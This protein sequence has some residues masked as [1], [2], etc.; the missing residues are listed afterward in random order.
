MPY[1]DVDPDDPNML[2]GVALP[3]DAQSMKQ[4][5]E[6]FA[7]E[8]AMLGFDEDRLI[9]LFRHPFYAGVHQALEVLGEETIREIIRESVGFW[10]KCRVHVRDSPGR[11]RGRSPAGGIE[12][13]SCRK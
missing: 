1:D 5:A 4:M 7:D 11:A 6:T 10:S 8:F 13:E 2:V 9:A 12:E 3:G